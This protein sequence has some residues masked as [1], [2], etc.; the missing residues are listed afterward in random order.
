[1]VKK[2]II[3]RN[4]CKFNVLKQ[5]TAFLR[6]V[7][8]SNVIDIIFSVMADRYHMCN[9]VR[10]Q[11][12]LTLAALL[13]LTTDYRSTRLYMRLADETYLK[14]SEVYSLISA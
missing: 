3:I 12:H 9:S 8:Q 10:G 5:V 6:G 11:D 1:M 14:I 4:I 2:I 7:S 13:N